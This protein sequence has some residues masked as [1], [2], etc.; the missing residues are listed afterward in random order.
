MS[1]DKKRQIKTCSEYVTS[2]DKGRKLAKVLLLKEEFDKKGNLI[3]SEQYNEQ[4]SLFE[5]EQMSYDHGFLV[6]LVS[7][8]YNNISIETNFTY[9]N[10]FLI[11]E[12]EQLSE[13]EFLETTYTYDNDGALIGT[14]QKDEEGNIYTREVIKGDSSKTITEIYSEEELYQTDIYHYD[15]RGNEIKNINIKY[16]P[17]KELPEKRE[18]KIVNESAYDSS[19][20]LISY[21]ITENGLLVHEMKVTYDLKGNLI[22][23]S[24]FNSD[25]KYLE[26]HKNLYSSKDLLVERKV[27]FDKELM[28][29][30]VYN[31]DSFDEILSFEK[32]EQ[33]GLGEETVT[34]HL[35]EYTYH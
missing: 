23:T 5:K 33:L 34:L 15:E 6:K 16:S 24:I 14:L 4:G 11:S 25:K 8:D 32:R 12:V 30:F 19:D 3:V 10:E 20:L 2:Y 29:I 17:Y 31:Y 9:K 21:K 7:T 18:S 26:I 35:F 1:V 27:F 13:S 22:Q 28:T